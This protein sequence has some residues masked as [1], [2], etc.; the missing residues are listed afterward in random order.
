MFKKIKNFISNNKQNL[1]I[2]LLLVITISNIFISNYSIVNKPL[3]DLERDLKLAME[4]G[5][6][7][8]L[9]DNYIA[10][11]DSFFSISRSFY[12]GTSNILFKDATLKERLINYVNMQNMRLTI[13]V[14]L[15]MFSVLLILISI[16]VLSV[17][18]LAKKNF[19]AFKDDFYT[20]NNNHNK[21]LKENIEESYKKTFMKVETSK[22]YPSIEDVKG[23]SE[24]TE[25]VSQIVD[26]LKIKINIYLWEPVYQKVLYY[27]AHQVL[28]KLCLLRLWLMMLI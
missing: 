17:K 22:K 16:F 24:I 25:E 9:S 14:L 12:I 13:E 11:K 3:T 26:F 19:S 8:I 15:F 7:I 2:T 10:I 4:S 28:E 6:Y 27:M 5:K 23:I 21:Q 1:I 18:S 20:I